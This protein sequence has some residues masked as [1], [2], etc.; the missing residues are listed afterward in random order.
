MVDSSILV[1]NERLSYSRSLTT[2]V[3]SKRFPRHSKLQHPFICWLEEFSRRLSRYLLYF[4]PLLLKPL[5]L[6]P[7]PLLSFPLE[8]LFLYSLSF[9]PLPFLLLFLFPH[10]FLD[11]LLLEHILILDKVLF[12]DS[13]HCIKVILEPLNQV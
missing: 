3:L 11:L 9:Q 8:P 5:P 10:L 2:S 6:D 12:S 4:C 13:Q 1:L 7:L